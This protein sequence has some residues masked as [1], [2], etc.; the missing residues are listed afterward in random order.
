MEPKPVPPIRKCLFGGGVPWFSCRAWR[1]CARVGN[2]SILRVPL[3][4]M[5]F[6]LLPGWAAISAQA[7]P[8]LGELARKERARKNAGSSRATLWS[9]EEV[10]KPHPESFPAVQARFAMPID[11]PQPSVSKR[12]VVAP[13]PGTE[14]PPGPIVLEN[15][16]CAL[17]VGIDGPSRSSRENPALALEHF[18]VEFLAKTKQQ[19]GAWRD[20]QLAGMPAAETVVEIDKPPPLRRMRVVLAVHPQTGLIYATAVLASPE[21]FARLSPALDA[22]LTTFEPVTL[23]QP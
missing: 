13:C 1:W 21:Y 18:K 12:L 9:N 7:N 6:L 5:A 22:I 23:D 10:Q 17:A 8:S 2:V 4:L 20:F 15:I 14:L 19:I 11:W 16:P 3:M